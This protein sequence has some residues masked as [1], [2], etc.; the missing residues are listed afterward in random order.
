[1]LLLCQKYVKRSP[2]FARVLKIQWLNQEGIRAK[3]VSFIHVANVVGIRQHEKGQ[4]P[5]LILW[6]GI[7]ENTPLRR[8]TSEAL[9]LRRMLHSDERVLPK[10][11]IEQLR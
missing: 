11:R 10:R 9:F 6:R 5:T 4:A 1:M 3:M 7:K 2:Q 8:M